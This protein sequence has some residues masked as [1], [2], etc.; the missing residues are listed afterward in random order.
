MERIPTSQLSQV[1]Q[2]IEV[3]T[4]D[5][6][7]ES[8]GNRHY[9]ITLRSTTSESWPLH[10]ELK[11]QNGPANKRGFNGITDEAL[12]AILIHR[13]EGFQK[14]PFKCV[15]NEMALSDLRGALVALEERTADRL[16]RGVE[17]E[18]KP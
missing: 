17:G 10:V 4:V 8:G 7:D 14:G 9:R 2:N 13:L 18:A 12:I 6:A 11:F 1:N 5:E 16:Q 15:E 3:H